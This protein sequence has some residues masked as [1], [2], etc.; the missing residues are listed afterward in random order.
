MI[1]AFPTDDW[2][3]D[4]LFCSFGPPFAKSVSGIDGSDLAAIALKDKSGNRIT[5]TVFRF[6]N[7]N[8]LYD[9]DYS[10]RPYKELDFGRND[11][12]LSMM[13]TEVHRQLLKNK[14]WDDSRHEMVIRCRQLSVEAKAAMRGKTK[15]VQL[16]ITVKDNLGRGPDENPPSKNH[17]PVIAHK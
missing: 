9:L 6:R 15:I 10:I 2:S 8:N 7:G 14:T 4:R 5:I 1:E 12:F 3:C 13:E 16:S 11:P 17:F